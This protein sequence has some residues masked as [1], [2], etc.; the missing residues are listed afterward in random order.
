MARV[1]PQRHT[2]KECTVLFN[3]I[4]KEWAVNVQFQHYHM[5]SEALFQ[6]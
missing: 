4:F 3:E 6:Y 1:G 5:E 2:E